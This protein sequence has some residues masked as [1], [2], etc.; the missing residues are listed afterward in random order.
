MSY[1]IHFRRADGEGTKTHKSG[2]G[3]AEA[4]TAALFFFEGNPDVTMVWVLNGQ[5]ELAFDPLT[6]DPQ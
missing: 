1:T 6:R 4:H 5:G 3:D 2:L